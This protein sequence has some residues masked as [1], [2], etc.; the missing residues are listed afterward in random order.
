M[1]KRKRK[2]MRFSDEYILIEGQKLNEKTGKL[3]PYSKRLY[4]NQ[5]GRSA[6]HSLT[7]EDDE[8]GTTEQSGQGTRQRD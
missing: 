6:S 7:R 5:D 3:E 4:W 1:G 8:H 2:R